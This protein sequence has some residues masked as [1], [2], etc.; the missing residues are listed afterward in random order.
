MCLRPQRQRVS[1]TSIGSAVVAGNLV[2]ILFVSLSDE[3]D[4]S[5]LTGV[6]LMTS[7]VLLTIGLLACIE[8]AR[9][10]VRIQPT[11]ALNEA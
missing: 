5:D 8:P 2:L 6:L 10:A 4:A 1:F 7:G 11:D 9:R 3:I